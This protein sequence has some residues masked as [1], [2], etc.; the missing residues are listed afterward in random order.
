MLDEVLPR[1]TG[2]ILASNYEAVCQR[3]RVYGKLGQ[4]SG[5]PHAG[6]KVMP[7]GDGKATALIQ[8]VL[9]TSLHR[10]ACCLYHQ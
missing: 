4:L 3:F 10:L 5:G 6:A 7:G 2:N 9:V 1:T 8:E